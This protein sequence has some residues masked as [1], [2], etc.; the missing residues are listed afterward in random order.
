MNIPLGDPIYPLTE[1]GGASYPNQNYM[2]DKEAV[3]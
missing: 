2:F 1:M 3:S